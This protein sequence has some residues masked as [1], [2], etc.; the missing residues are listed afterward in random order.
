MSRLDLDMTAKIW[1][2]ALPHGIK[3]VLL[4]FTHHFNAAGGLSWPGIPRVA[5]MCGMS[6]RTVQGHTPAL[7][8]T[9]RRLIALQ[10]GRPAGS[11]RSCRLASRARS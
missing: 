2:S 6:E 5:R 1:R 9:G 3:Q 7:E 10:C 8:R 4:C 11:P